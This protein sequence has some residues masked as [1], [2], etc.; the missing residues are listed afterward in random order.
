LS[1]NVWTTDG[2]R[3]VEGVLPKRPGHGLSGS[4]SDGYEF[5]GRVM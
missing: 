5:V 3:G 4:Q 2:H 1:C